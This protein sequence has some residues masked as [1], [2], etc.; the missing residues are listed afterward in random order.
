MVI[1]ADANEPVRLMREPDIKAW[2]RSL[3]SLEL[4]RDQDELVNP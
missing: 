3:S 4:V 2:I 1:K